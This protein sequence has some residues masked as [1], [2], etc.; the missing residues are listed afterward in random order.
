M[1][2]TGAA[3]KI[4]VALDVADKTEALRLVEQLRDRIGFFKVGLELFTAAGPEAVRDIVR[5]GAKI[6]LDLKL[7]DIPNT[8]ARAVAAAADLH[9]ELLTL[10]LS[11]GRAMIEAARS[12]AADRLHLV[13][14]TALTSHSDE[15]LK[16]A[17]IADSMNDHVLRLAGIGAS[18]GIGFLVASARELAPLRREFG[19]KIKIITPGIR[20]AWSEAADQHRITTPKQALDS[21]SDYLVIGRPITGHARPAEALDRILAELAE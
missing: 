12:A 16:S 21:G 11:G 4:I 2:R 19:Q 1:T 17:G 8:V 5:T 13:G 6:F 14:V 15:T 3:E 7:Y 20:P 9:V 10:H 18:C